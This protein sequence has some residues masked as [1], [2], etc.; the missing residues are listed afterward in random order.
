MYEELAALVD[1]QVFDE[2][3]IVEMN[4]LNKVSRNSI[5]K[6]LKYLSAIYEFTLNNQRWKVFLLLWSIAE[7]ADKR[8]MTLLYALYRDELL[9]LS[10]QVVLNT[11]LGKKVNL[12]LIIKA[13]NET[14]PNR[15]ASTTLL[16]TA[17]N[18]ASSW[19]QAGYIEGKMKK[20][21]VKVE[22]G[23]PAVLFAIYLGSCDGLVGE[24]LL[25][26]KWI[27]TLEI[28]ENN[29]HEL[30]SQASRHD[31]IDFKKAGGVTV[32]Q[33]DNLLNRIE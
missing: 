30:L 14:W 4:I 19:K 20:I 15:F 11:P 25:K 21:R 33:L 17:Q 28:P 18:I 12:K 31:L 1:Q 13:I 3:T 7:E 16:S 9:R 5:N 26:T 10:T 6:T 8:I 22:P 23:F 24:D 2:D 27:K 29:L 32:L